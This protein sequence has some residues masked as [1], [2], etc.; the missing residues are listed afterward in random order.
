MSPSGVAVAPRASRHPSSSGSASA[1]ARFRRSADEPFILLAYAVLRREAAALANATPKAPA[2]PEPEEIHRLRVAARR[3][4]VALR[5]F[6]DVL[7]REDVTRYRR[8]LKWFASSL[9]EVRDLDVYT[10]SLK[11]YVRRLPAARRR[12]FRTYQLYLRRERKAARGRAAEAVASPRATV[13]CKDLAQFVAAGPSPAALRRW[14]QLASREAIPLHFRRSSGR[15]RQFGN[16]LMKRARPNELHQLRIRIK[17]LRYELEF[18][19]AVYPPLAQTANACKVLQDLL[20]AHQDVYAATARLRSFSASLRKQGHTGKLAPALLELRAN[21]LK[22]ARDLRG[23][24]RATWPGF[25]A[26]VAAAHKLIS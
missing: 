7:P 24:F 18:F 13:L 14:S 11:R 1:A 10:E 3:L 26:A 21:Q 22:H 9:G 19:A 6:S 25:V 15:V 20:G 2:S 23:L 17:R 8:D 16:A 4:R 5:L 12:A